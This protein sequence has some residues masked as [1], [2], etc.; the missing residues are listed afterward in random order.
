MPD[1]PSWEIAKEQV[2]LNT[3]EMGVSVARLVNEHLPVRAKLR[4]FRGR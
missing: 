2:K 3:V 1:S 4:C